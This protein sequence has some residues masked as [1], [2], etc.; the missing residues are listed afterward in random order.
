MQAQRYQHIYLSPHLDDV[1]LSCGGEIHAQARAGERA[2]VV[3]FFAA[4][5][6][7]DELT[8]FARELKARWGH[9]PDPVVL[10]R[11]EDLAALQVVGA[12]A[13]HLPYADCVYR[14][15]SS[16]GE[17]YYPDEASIFGAIHRAEAEWDRDLLAAFRK[18]VGDLAGATVYAPLGA[19]HH[20]DHLLVRR[21]AFALLLGGEEVLFYEDYP[22]ADR[23][24]VVQDALQALPGEC[25]SRERRTLHEENLRAK[26]D[27][28]AC[29]ASQINTFWKDAQGRADLEAMRRA[30][31][32]YVR[33]GS[34]NGY[35][36]RLWRLAP[37]CV[38][39]LRALSDPS[40]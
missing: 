14:H 30:L 27:A 7:D 2:L 19:G 33:V 15:D 13:C 26:T 31:L 11:A 25:W 23:P 12:D 37:A 10:R 5:P 40:H 29:Y 35:A 18:V 24:E 3:T 22:Y 32:A 20:V 38:A 4:S 8:P 28:V 34:R 6:Q 16:T 39:G 21:V 9:A 1:V 36:E 17:A